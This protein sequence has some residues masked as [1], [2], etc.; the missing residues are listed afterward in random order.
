[1]CLSKWFVDNYIQRCFK[2]CP[3][4]VSRLF[5]DVSTSTKV[6]NAVSAFVRWRLLA[7]HV[8]AFGTFSGVR[9]IITNNISWLSD[10]SIMFVFRERTTKVGS[11]SANVLY[12]SRISTRCLENKQ[13]FTE[14]RIA[15]CSNDSMHTAW[16][17]TLLFLGTRQQY[18]VARSSPRRDDC[19]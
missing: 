4:S 7:T 16:R 2:H 5:D 18:I 13:R 12:C 6:Q 8:S 11:L 10:C 17:C 3:D 19:I 15:G 1:V 14:R 9:N